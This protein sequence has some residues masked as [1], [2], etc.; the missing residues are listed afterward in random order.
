MIF[1]YSGC[2]NSRF[3]AEELSAALGEKLLFIPD[4]QREGFS[5]Y[6]I[7][8]G[9]SI[10]FVFPIY[11]WAAPQLVENFVKGVKWNGKSA[12]T[13]MS[14]TCGDEMGI[15]HKTFGKVL[16]SVGLELAAAY[17]FQMPE[18][19]LALPGFHLDTD[20]G[21]K[22]KI[23]LVKARLPK[24][25][26]QIR[27]HKATMDDL[28]IGPLA[29]FKSHVIK[30]GFVASASDK[31]YF[32]TDACNGCGICEKVCPLKNVKMEEKHPK[33]LGHCT[34][35]MACYH[36]CPQNAIQFGSFTKGKGQY[37]FG[38]KK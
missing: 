30:A 3:I 13:W 34:Q 36:H 14:C 33:W 1:Y 27:E 29:W 7:A 38:K 5:E 32:T 22:K 15:A 6:Q 24:V 18:T 20:E 19:Y 2:G 31:K 16:Q 28:L 21:A 37:Y 26:E 4:L 8:E 25:A 12:Y 35:C 9:E 11:S 17:C 23:E 10:G